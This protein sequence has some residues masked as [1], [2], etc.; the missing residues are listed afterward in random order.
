MSKRAGNQYFHQFDKLLNTQKKIL[1]NYFHKNRNR[2]R[3]IFRRNIH[4][5][6]CLHSIVNCRKSQ[7][8]TVNYYIT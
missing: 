4:N 3:V 7:T 6:P 5:I 1:F 8:I 2:F